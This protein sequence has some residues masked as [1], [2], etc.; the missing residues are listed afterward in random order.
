[1]MSSDAE[2]ATAALPILDPQAQELERL[3][4]ANFLISLTR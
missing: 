4:V 2:P 3:M 1:M